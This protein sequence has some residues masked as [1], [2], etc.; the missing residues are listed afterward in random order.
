MLLAVLV[1]LALAAYPAAAALAGDAK[2]STAIL[3]GPHG[4][5]RVDLDVDALITVEGRGGPVQFEVK[6]GCMRVVSV[7]CPDR[8]CVRSGTLKAG[9]P[10][11]C[12]PNG[13]YARMADSQ[14]GDLDAISR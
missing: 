11:V 9:A 4:E 12:A 7:T 8:V 10:I 14:G 5:T 2:S 3:V 13:V 6:D 1:A